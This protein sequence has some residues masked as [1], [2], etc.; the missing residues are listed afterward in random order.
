ME[1]TKKQGFF[2]N[3]KNS[4]F[5]FDSYQE[6]AM[7]DMK[8]GIFYFLKLSI[9]FSVVISIVFAAL[10]VTVTVPTVKKF[11]EGDIPN[12]SYSNGTLD[13]QSEEPV[14]IDKI[15]DDVLIIADT[16]ELDD[17]KINE[18]KDKINLYEIGVLIL[19]DKIYLKN[20]YTLSG[21]QEMKLSDIESVY[22]KSEFTK[23]DILNDMNSINMISLC[24]SLAFTVFL[25]FFLIFVFMSIL[26]IIILAL[27]SNIIAMLSRVKMK[28]SALVNISI[29]AM[30][31]PIVLLLAYAV[32]LLT[33]GFEIKY[34]NIM[35][36]GISYIYVF[37]AI[38]LIRQNLIKQQIEL[39]TIVQKQQEL[40]KE[41]EEKETEEPK[42]NKDDNKSNDKKDED[43]KEENKDNNV[44]KE[45]SG[46][47]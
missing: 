31:L 3:V 6:F 15:A 4:I 1:K 44:G 24:I 11:I 23:Q 19:K 40:K 17:A 20:A 33:T 28:A 5:N 35:Y 18:Y 10:Q 2:K 47:V 43:K 42:E 8:K 26:D 37:T 9:L 7:Q 29:H 12:F 14:T 38:F 41:L 30:T 22:G 45:A 32:V 16:K 25:G 27:L 34:F 13:L 46:E 39:T 21:I 36:R